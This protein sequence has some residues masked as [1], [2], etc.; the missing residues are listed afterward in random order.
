VISDDGIKPTSHPVLPWQQWHDVQWHYIAPGKLIQ[1][2]FIES[3]NDRLREQFLHG[4]LFAKPI[5]TE[6]N[7]SNFR[8]SKDRAQI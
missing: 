2:G 7:K 3:F 4:H 6:P 1:N 8:R 5:V